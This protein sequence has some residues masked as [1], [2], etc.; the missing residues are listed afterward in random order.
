LSILRQKARKKGKKSP[1]QK[2][3]SHFRKLFLVKV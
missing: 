2:K 1:K 3:K